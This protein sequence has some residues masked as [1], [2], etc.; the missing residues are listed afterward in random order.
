MNANE[1]LTWMIEAVLS[2][3]SHLFR[4]QPAVERILFHITKLCQ[5][6]TSSKLTHE[7]SDA[8]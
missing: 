8:M 4:R 5:R 3:V 1:E 7:E 6:A 2:H